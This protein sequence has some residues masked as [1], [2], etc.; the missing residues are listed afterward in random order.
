MLSFVLV[1]VLIV[2][3]L[4]CLLVRWELSSKVKTINLIPGPKRTW[5]LGNAWSMPTASSSG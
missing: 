4:V 1:L 5:I 2:S 3:V